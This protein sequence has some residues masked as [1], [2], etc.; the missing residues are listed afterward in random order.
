MASF[1]VEYV[2]YRLGQHRVIGAS[3]SRVADRLRLGR[4]VVPVSLGEL[5]AVW[6]RNSRGSATTA[7]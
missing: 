4:L 7:A 6:V 2:L 1:S 5:Y 3:M